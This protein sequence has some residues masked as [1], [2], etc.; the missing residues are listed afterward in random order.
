[1]ML[2]YLLLNPRVP[3]GRCGGRIE[4]DTGQCLRLLGRLVIAEAPL[5]RRLVLL[6]C[7]LLIPASY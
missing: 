5:G 3:V 6:P 4:I 7:F 1:M 2:R